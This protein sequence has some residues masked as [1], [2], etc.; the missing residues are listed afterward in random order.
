[1][2]I[3]E[4]DH[5]GARE[6]ELHEKA[7]ER[8]LGVDSPRERP[9]EEAS[10]PLQ[11][12]RQDGQGGVTSSLRRGPTLQ[13][14]ERAREQVEQ[15]AS[16]LVR[17]SL[18][19]QEQLMESLGF[20]EALLDRRLGSEFPERLEAEREL[21][22]ESE[23]HGDVVVERQGSVAHARDRTVRRKANGPGVPLAAE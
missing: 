10:Q 7:I 17:E 23:R 5:V 19:R 18:E 2:V 6:I 12:R 21:Q 16:A 8:E 20:L 3:D 11:Q 9:I 15:D 1:L 22:D 13:V 4:A 14:R